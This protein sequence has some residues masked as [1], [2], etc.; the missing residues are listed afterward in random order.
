MATKIENEE[1]LLL[2]RKFSAYLRDVYFAG[3]NPGD[4]DIDVS[5]HSVAHGVAS[6]SVFNRKSALVGILVAHQLFYCL[7]NQRSG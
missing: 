6:T 3:F 5:R 2:P 4:Q 7:D 1:C